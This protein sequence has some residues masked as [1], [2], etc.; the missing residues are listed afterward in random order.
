MREFPSPE[1]ST[2]ETKDQ[3]REK[4]E[5]ELLNAKEMLKLI[6]KDICGTPESAHGKFYQNFGPVPLPKNVQGIY[7]KIRGFEEHAQ[8]LIR[9]QLGIKGDPEWDT[10]CYG[11]W[12]HYISQYVDVNSPDYIKPERRRLKGEL[13]SGV[14]W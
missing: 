13:E 4:R 11:Q 7:D 10:F 12:D 3:G 9:K 1:R 2:S 14:S 6:W 5:R 8:E